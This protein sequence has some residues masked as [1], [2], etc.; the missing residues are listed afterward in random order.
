MDG[1]TRHEVIITPRT[2]V[3]DRIEG[4][5]E[6]LKQEVSDICGIRVPDTYTLEIHLE[7]PFG[8][9]LG[10][11]S[12]STAY[13]VPRDE[14]E[15]WGPDFSFH[16]VGTGPFMLQEWQHG[17]HVS[18]ISNPKYFSSPPRLKGIFYRIIPEDLTA[19]VE[20]EIANLDI[21]RIPSQFNNA[22]TIF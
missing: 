12:L 14:I 5:K 8:P 11:L 6:F 18:L 13:V 21:I 2:W 1:K 4:A 19:M 20:F 3:L 17:R 7:E 9:F 16:V 22:G 15:R 10:L